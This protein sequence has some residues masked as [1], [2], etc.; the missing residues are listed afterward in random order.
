MAT[1][2]TVLTTSTTTKAL[3]Q[4]ELFTAL[5]ALD[6]VKARPELVEGLTHRLDKLDK[7]RAVSGKPTKAQREAEQVKADILSVLS[8]L[9]EGEGMTSA[10]IAEELAI[11]T[12]SVAGHLRK[13]VDA[14]KVC[15][16]IV[17]R[18]SVYTLA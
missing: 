18:Q 8:G 17:K 16:T 9:P 7:P 14:G 13:L 11:S 3:T 1:T 5:L 2:S 4:R 15:K 10:Q 12:G 6:E